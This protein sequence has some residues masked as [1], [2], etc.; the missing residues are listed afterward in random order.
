MSDP[1]AQ[2]NPFAASFGQPPPSP[3]PPGPAPA[4]APVPPVSTASAAVA[5]AAALA[6][7]DNPFQA[8]EPL[9]AP[10]ADE[11]RR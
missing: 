6:R 2:A 9:S 7:E 10:S 3:P 4:P 1:F 11:L 5:E 8:V